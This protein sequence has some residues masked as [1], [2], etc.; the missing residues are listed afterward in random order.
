[1]LKSKKQLSVC[2]FTFKKLNKLADFTNFL[3]FFQFLFETENV[4]LLHLDPHTD[5]RSGSRGKNKGGCRSTA[6]APALE[7]YCTPAHRLRNTA[8]SVNRSNSTSASEISFGNHSQK[9]IHAQL[10]NRAC[11]QLENRAC[12]NSKHGFRKRKN[13]KSIR[14]AAYRYTEPVLEKAVGHQAGNILKRVI[15]L[16]F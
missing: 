2:K 6:L 1:M 5:C 10:E 8:V 13:G 12:A 4:F 14:Y 3:A 11:A 16:L 7:N 15:D 9:I